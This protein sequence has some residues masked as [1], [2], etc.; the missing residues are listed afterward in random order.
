M[1]ERPF[2]H[3]GFFALRTP[4]LPLEFLQTW[5]SKSEPE[6]RGNPSQNGDGNSVVAN[7]DELRAKL[8]GFF[9]APDLRDA[10]FV[11]SPAVEEALRRDGATKDVDKRD[12]LDASLTKYLMRMA[13]RCTPFGLFAGVSVGTFSDRTELR[14]AP[15][16]R[17]RRYTR[18]DM[19]Y[20]AMLVDGLMKDPRV[21]H[22]VRYHRNSTLHVTAG[23]A[24]YVEHRPGK[25]SRSYFLVSADLDESLREV[26]E[27]SAEGVTFDELA[28]ALACDGITKSCGPR[29]A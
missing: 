5:G 29:R 21:R 2:T 14:L 17:Y 23:R 13:G 12:R 1:S 16:S 26:L 27:R 28:S 7:E 3:S 19:G 25:R 24:R 6:T 15:R 22:T 4:L 20:L 11:A 18:I 9:D 8:R 10:L